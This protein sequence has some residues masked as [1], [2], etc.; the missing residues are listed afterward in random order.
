[1]KKITFTTLFCCLLGAIVM[2][3]TPEKY[4]RVSIDLRGRDIANLAAL[5]IET[6]HGLYVA[7]HSL[8][9]I[10]SESEWQLV[11]QSGYAGE[12]LIP[13]MQ[14]WDRA[15][16]EK[17]AAQPRSGAC[18]T[19]PIVYATPSNYTYGTMAGY[20]KYQEMLDILDDMAAKYPNLITTRAIVSDTIQTH[21]G[22]PQWWVRVSD[23][24]NVDEDEPEVLYT[25]LH[26]AREPN[27]LSQMI[28]Y[29]WYLLENYETDPQVKYILDNAELYF[30]PCVNPDGYIYNETTNP[31]GYGYWRK[32]RR[33]NDDGTFGVDLNRN[34]GYQWGFSNSGS[35]PNSVSE[36]YRGPAPFSEPETR[37]VRDFCLQHE[38]VLAFNYHTFSNLLIYPWGYSDALAEPAL[39]EL[40]DLFTRD[41]HY[42][43]GVATETVGYFVNGTSDDWMYGGSDIFA[44]TPEVGPSM[45][46]FWPPESAID[47]LN[48]ENVWQNLSMALCALRFGTVEDQS[49]NS[50]ALQP[51]ALPFSVKRFGFQDGPLSV[52]LSALTNNVTIVN[53]VQVFDLE[54]LETA[55]GVFDLAPTLDAQPGQAIILVLTLDNGAYQQHDTL[56][57]AFN[58]PIQIAFTDNAANLDN[59]WTA[60]WNTTTAQF[61]SPPTSF[62]DSPGGEYFAS[63]YNTLAISEAVAIPSD[64]VNPELRFWARWAIEEQYDYLAVN[65]AGDDNNFQPLCGL[66]T[67]PGTDFQIPGAPIYDG[68]QT[69]WVEERI[70]LQDYVGQDF[71]F[72]F[73]MVSNF[74]VQYDGFYFDNLRVVFYDPASVSTVTLPVESFRLHQNTPNPSQGNT[75]I[76]WEN[77]GALTGTGQLVVFN[78]LGE[79]VFAQNIDPV[80]ASQ[81][82]INV[83]D[84]AP[85]VYAYLL[86]GDG[87]QSAPM[88]MV[89]GAGK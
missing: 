62:T 27:S 20:Y 76:V 42:K 68:F 55:N 87:W 85:G 32:N 31:D 82:T 1:M 83:K 34:Y 58:G 60:S 44:Y 14:A 43:A 65:G 35:S 40:A 5:G 53:P 67:K 33:D 89:V 61:V 22:R 13:D 39:S 15:M 48:K 75:R 86:R 46:G 50:F 57:K 26:H 38:F 6:D 25:A 21:E 84:W 41:N 79:Q 17:Y 12:I 51:F 2:A 66:Y 29:L 18:E 36:T 63:D 52:S 81:T 74:S 45:Y 71:R 54:Q 56:Y 80:K 49:A 73:A 24:P 28:F 37:M 3:Q 4:L 19:A 70:S 10:V 77:P 8:V 23:N 88:K 16:A 72:E 64:A 69:D 78:A 7:D 47:G 59:W 30:I 11:R 9:T